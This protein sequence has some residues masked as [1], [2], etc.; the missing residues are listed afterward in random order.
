MFLFPNRNR[1]LQR[2]N[3]EPCRFKCH[4]A[5]GRGS[6]DDNRRL[7]KLQLTKPMGNR[8]A[9]NL[10]PVTPSFR[11]YFVQS[12][13]CGALVSFVGHGVDVVSPLGMVSDDTAEN[14][15]RAR[16]RSGGPPRQDVT[17]QVG[18]GEHN[19]VLFLVRRGF[20][21]SASVG[22]NLSNASLASLKGR[23]F[24]T[25]WLRVHL[26][27]DFAMTDS[28]QPGTQGAGSS[29]P[30]P[31]DRLW[32]HPTEI[33]DGLQSRRGI[34]NPTRGLW[35]LIGVAVGS[36]MF[37]SLLTVGIL[38][39]SGLL[40]GPPKPTIRDR[41]LTVANDDARTDAADA[42]RPAMVEINYQ[43]PKGPATA[44][45]FCI[46]QGS[47]I[48]TSAIVIG[49]PG[50]ISIVTAKGETYKA[51]V[52]GTDATSGL[53][54]LETEGSM[55][56]ASLA[57]ASPKP[58]D[59]VIVIG[60]GA[61]I[62]EGIIN[63]TGSVAVSKNGVALPNLLITSALPINNVPGSAL[64]NGQG[65]IA[66]VIIAGNLGAVPID[67]ARSVIEALT[68]P[69]K[70]THAWVG[71]HGKDSA[72]GPVVTKVDPGSPAAIAGIK[73]GDVIEKIDGRVTLSMIDLQAMIRWRWARDEV[74]ISIQR[75]QLPLEV[76]LIAMAPPEVEPDI[77]GAPP[78]TAATAPSA[79]ASP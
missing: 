75:S 27:P 3:R 55:P 72:R 31:L 15:N 19:P 9:F 33:N 28:D 64:V 50:T 62:G 57:T 20:Q 46:K 36:A 52:V 42:V 41:L 7:T 29:L 79:T 77:S 35:Q 53:A 69:T 17:R 70:T 44:A 47:Y 51:S 63:S 37:G 6:D 76:T 26:S 49:K 58:G 38:G 8:E 21:H 61:T 71:I 73:R 68:G 34:E 23:W 16:T 48:L 67:Y 11:R 54:I 32:R 74:V 22:S 39:L 65:K 30:D 45:G 12:V 56:I 5:V 43:S 60:S 4:I 78:T 2:V 59:S 18:F 1:Q 13:Q 24:S 66:G 40:S 25:L 10:R 14:N